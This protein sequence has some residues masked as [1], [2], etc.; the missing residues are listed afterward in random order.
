MYLDLKATQKT[1]KSY[2]DA[3][4]GILAIC[5]RLEPSTNDYNG[6]TVLPTTYRPATGVIVN[7]PE[8][9]TIFH[10]S[11]EELFEWGKPKFISPQWNIWQDS[12][13]SIHLSILV[14][15][16][17]YTWEIGRA[18]YTD[19]E[20]GK[21]YPEIKP[22]IQEWSKENIHLECNHWGYRNY[23]LKDWKS[24]YTEIF[25]LLDNNK[26]GL[27]KKYKEQMLDIDKKVLHWQE[28]INN[29]KVAL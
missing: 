28:T 11:T 22:S 1:I 21:A 3:Y 2:M 4:K 6:R 17:I 15:F 19:E 16:S 27:T 10:I 24:K 20:T 14:Q 29:F 26:N 12:F 8:L 13:I 18:A 23:G 7:F 25:E 9:A 5:P